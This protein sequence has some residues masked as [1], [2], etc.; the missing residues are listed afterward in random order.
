M[1][2]IPP[3]IALLL[4]IAGTS[5][6]N[7]QEAHKFLHNTN[8][9]NALFDCAQKTIGQ[10]A[11]QAGN[12]CKC[13]YDAFGSSMKGL[14]PGYHWDCGLEQGTCMSDVPATTSGNY[15][16]AAPA[17]PPPQLVVPFAPPR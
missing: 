11:C 5:P 17:L 12:R 13:I 16:T 2:R 6:V 14:P 8:P 1:N 4:A 7:A 10:M 15:G 3:L 9:S